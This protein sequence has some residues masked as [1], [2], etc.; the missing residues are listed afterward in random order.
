MRAA[1]KEHLIDL[2][3]IEKQR[4][5]HAGLADNYLQRLPS[6]EQASIDEIID[7]KKE[8][9]EPV[10]RFRKKIML[11]SESIQGLP[12]DRDFVPECSLLFDKEIAPAILEIE[13]A[14]RENGFMKNIGNK[15]FT[16]EGS[17]K[18]TGGLIVSV[19]AAGVLPSF[20]N[21]ASIETATIIAGGSIAATKIAQ[22]YL[23]YCNGKN[24]IQSKDLYFYYKAGKLLA[25]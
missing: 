1:V 23:E 3:E 21:I 10:I 17:W 14:T 22:A 7:I 24:D 19:A 20:T 4:I 11:Y 15:F 2:S 18:T 8:L 9:S 13:E 25:K 6:F 5:T 12:W 16:D